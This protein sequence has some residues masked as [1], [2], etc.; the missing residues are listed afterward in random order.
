MP[1]NHCCCM[2]EPVAGGIA[3][4]ITSG[5]VD[6]IRSYIQNADDPE[7]AWKEASQE[8]VIRARTTFRQDHGEVNI[9]DLSALKRN[10]S[11]IGRSAREIQ[12]RGE[13]MEF[14]EDLID[15]MGDFA[16]ACADY[17]NSTSHNNYKKENEFSEQLSDIGQ[18]IIDETTS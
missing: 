2:V 5:T 7:E 4:A 6:A 13:V 15:L 18:K 9:S 11:T 3:S 12:V 16:T 1:V 8:C 17:A 10:I 14:D